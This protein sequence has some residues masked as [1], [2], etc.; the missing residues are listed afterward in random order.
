MSKISN[1]IENFYARLEIISH[2]HFI[3][4]M[5]IFAITGSLALFLTVQVL[6]I[7]NLK[8]LL[9]PFIFWPLRIITLFIIYQ[10]TLILVSIP[11]GEYRYFLKFVRKF[12]LRVGIK[13]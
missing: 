12:L 9:S 4:I 13:I 7:M 2:K 8:E 11:F 3:V 6:S 10:I 5:T 1:Y